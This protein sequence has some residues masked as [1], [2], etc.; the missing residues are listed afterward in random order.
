MSRMASL[1]KTQAVEQL[2]TLPVIFAL[3]EQGGEFELRPRSATGTLLTAVTERLRLASASGA[4]VRIHDATGRP[5]LL[6]LRVESAAM[7]DTDTAETVFRAVGLTLDQAHRKAERVAING[8]AWLTAVNCQNVVDR[9]VVEARIVDAAEGGVAVLTGRLL[10][11]GDRL[12]LRARFF[13][14]WLDAEVRVA[15]I[16]EHDGMVEAGCQ[17][18]AISTDQRRVLRAVME[19]REPEQAASVHSLLREF[20][21]ENEVEPEP[22]PLWRRL[23]RKA[24]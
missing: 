2:S 23:L 20:E 17:F 18:I 1:T 15:R 10:R 11:P 24:V 3:D 8:Q 14:T 6:T 7:R 9:D 5:W 19:H 21:W 12:L 13:A 16:C 4:T 22:S